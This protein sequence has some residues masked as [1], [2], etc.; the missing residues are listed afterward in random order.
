MS[1]GRRNPYL[2]ARRNAFTLIELL[3]VVGIIALVVGILIPTL[4]SV[5]DAARKTSTMGLANDVTTAA[6]TF[7]TDNRRAPGHFSQDQMGTSAAAGVGFTNS[8]NVLIDLAGGVVPN[9]GT[10]NPDNDNSI[11]DVGPPG[12]TSGAGGPGGA[13]PMSDDEF[14]RID[15]SLVGS[16]QGDHGGY[17]RLGEEVLIPVEGQK[18]NDPAAK[19]RTD[20]VD[21]VD[22][23]GQPMLLFTANEGA[24]LPTSKFAAHHAENTDTPTLDQL[25]MFYWACNAGYLASERLGARGSNQ[26]R[27]SILGGATPITEEHLGLSLEGLL[28]SPAYPGNDADDPFNLVPL[29]PRGKVVVVSAGADRIY[30]ARDQDP[31]QAIPASGPQSEWIIDYAP[32]PA[33][34]QA[35]DPRRNEVEAFDDLVMSAGE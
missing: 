5:R 22:Y 1:R 27:D 4:G 31:G 13:G 21:L 30:F 29:R 26:F 24:V 9:S 14:I 19:D 17:L 33:A 35:G 7:M 25:A 3:V 18:G 15:N 34:D 2:Y 12:A 11:V 16:G 8:E 20:M 32:R 23:F 28:G 6:V 10:N